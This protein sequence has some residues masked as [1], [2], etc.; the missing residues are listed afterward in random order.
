MDCMANNEDM[1][2]LKIEEH[3][4]HYLFNSLLEVEKQQEP[5]GLGGF[6]KE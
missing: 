1:F 4:P 3:S 2:D 6:L 5:D